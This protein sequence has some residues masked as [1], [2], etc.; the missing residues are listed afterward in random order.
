MSS[1]VQKFVLLRLCELVVAKEPPLLHILSRWPWQPSLLCGNLY[2]CYYLTFVS[3]TYDL[4]SNSSPVLGVRLTSSSQRTAGSFV[5]IVVR[6]VTLECVL[7]NQ[8]IIDLASRRLSH[9]WKI[10]LAGPV[11]QPWCA[12]RNAGAQNGWSIEPTYYF[13]QRRYAIQKLTSQGK[14]SC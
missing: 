11:I 4:G 9:W 6:D 5:R 10:Q 3:L 2:R 7:E 8:P 12:R 1:Y 14:R 13:A